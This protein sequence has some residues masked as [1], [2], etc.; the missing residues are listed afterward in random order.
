M[1]KLSECWSTVTT[2]E[3]SICRRKMKTPSFYLSGVLLKKQ[4]TVT[5]LVVEH[6]PD[7]KRTNEP[8]K[9]N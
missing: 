1:S 9:G 2:V 6:Y 4:R 5:T 8:S 3:R 7:D